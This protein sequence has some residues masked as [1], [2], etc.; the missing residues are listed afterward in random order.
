M[1]QEIKNCQNCK[2]DF[3]IE[4]EDFKFYEK[5]KVPPPTWCPECRL[6]RRLVWRNEHSLFRRPNG[7][8]GSVGEHISIYNPEEKVIT[9]DKDFWWSDKWDP[10]KYGMDYDFSKP[11]FQQFKELLAKVPHVAFF[12]SKSTNA[13]FCNFTV[14]MKNCYLVTAAW[15]CEDSMY[16]NRQF[17]CKFTHDSYICFHTEYCYEDIY[18]HGSNKLFFSRECDGCLDSYFLYDCRNCSNCI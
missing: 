13:R 11:F 6:L 10:C 3:T 17:H 8:P 7:T 16:S 12:D 1:K 15:A 9:Y 5:I 4:S 2:K 14:E 18:C